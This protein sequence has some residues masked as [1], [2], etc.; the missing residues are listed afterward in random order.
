LDYL[1]SLI[2]AAEVRPF[3]GTTSKNTNFEV[4]VMIVTMQGYAAVEEMQLPVWY[5]L[6][7]RKGQRWHT[8]IDRC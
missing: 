4:G 3:D 6:I 8:T 2:K 7:S 1:R 5:V